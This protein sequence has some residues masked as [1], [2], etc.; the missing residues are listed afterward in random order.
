MVTKARDKF[1]NETRK[2]K[3]SIKG[4]IV[5]NGSYFL[6]T[7]VVHNGKSQRLQKT[8]GRVTE[9]SRQ[10]AEQLA[11]DTKNKAREFGVDS[12]KGFGGLSLE[13]DTSGITLEQVVDE[14]L[15]SPNLE[16]ET[17]RKT[18]RH[19]KHWS[20][21]LKLPIKSI[22][23]STLREWYKALVDWALKNNFTQVDTDALRK[24]HTIFNYAME[25]EYLDYNIV[26]SITKSKKIKRK[27]PDKLKT[28]AEERLGLDNGELSKF[29]YG[30]LSLK[31]R[32]SK[33][34]VST[35]IDIIWT[36]LLTG[37]RYNEIRQMRWSWF[38]SLDLEKGFTSFIAPK[39]IEDK[40]IKI[41][42]VKMGR[43]ENYYPLCLMLQ[44]LF[45]QR[46]KNRVELS[47][48]M[49][50]KAPL[51]YVFPNSESFSAFTN[52][53]GRIEEVCKNVGINKKV[54]HHSFRFTF[55]DI[56]NRVTNKSHL[57]TDALHHEHRDLANKVYSNRYENRK[58][59][60]VLFQN[61][62]NFLSKSIPVSYP[63]KEG[64]FLTKS[65]TNRISEIDNIT[66][67]KEMVVD[68]SALRD[69]VMGR[70]D[71]FTVYNNLDVVRE[72]VLA[73]IKKENKYAKDTYFED[74]ENLSTFEK[75]QVSL[76]KKIYEIVKEFEE[77][78]KETKKETSS[79][80]EYEELIIKR[81]TDL[82]RQF[83]INI[84]LATETTIKI[85]DTMSCIITEMQFLSSYFKNNPKVYKHFVM[86]L[87]EYTQSIKHQSKALID[88]KT[89]RDNKKP[90]QDIY[91]KKEKEKVID[92]E[93]SK[94]M[95]RG[96]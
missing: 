28:E 44:Q 24:L 47:E 91:D 55:T 30:L 87:K 51:E 67:I 15:A 82:R 77:L 81:A 53:K 37:G 74:K 70:K 32:T 4:L 34:N 60:R 48:R 41:N 42:C 31:P 54:N 65:G 83:N 85:L 75:K 26:T 73:E 2:I 5:K 27:K 23:K 92:F 89:I 40:G 45:K 49:K 17:K 64:K 79:I 78:S 7:S 9:I 58:E 36:Y 88:L 16:P 66:E 14:Y 18:H 25:M 93:V 6:Q 56:A 84:K 33:P 22:D 1:G 61:V 68:E 96:T 20:G 90:L 59:L 39:K 62:E 50:S 76:T 46:F 80:K 71:L 63:I 72:Q 21:L 95:L 43:K 10:Q 35:G 69:V 57:V 11:I 86:L 3:T 12:V 29:V 38:D 8:I 19:K 94:K 13:K 52:P